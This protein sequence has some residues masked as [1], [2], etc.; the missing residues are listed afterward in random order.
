MDVQD[1]FLFLSVFPPHFVELASRQFLLLPD[2]G[3]PKSFPKFIEALSCC[4]GI[5]LLDR[6][7]FSFFDFEE[8][9]IPQYDLTNKVTVPRIFFPR[10]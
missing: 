9:L 5:L 1:F 8:F 7:P 6:M 2:P 3:T 4:V 10:V